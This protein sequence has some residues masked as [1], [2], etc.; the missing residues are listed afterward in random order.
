MNI[1]ALYKISYSFDQN[2]Y[3][4]HRK[5]IKEKNCIPN[6]MSFERINFFEIES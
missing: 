4:V 5:I 6:Q 2:L 3:F 1:I